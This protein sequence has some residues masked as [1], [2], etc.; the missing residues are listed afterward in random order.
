MKKPIDINTWERKDLFLFFKQFEEPF[1]GVCVEVDVTAAYEQSK[2]QGVS[3]FLY[4]LHK[5]LAA[6]N[7][8]EAFRYR[9]DGE[10]VFLYDVVHASP[11][12]N[13]ANGTF[14]FAYMDY[15]PD[16]NDFVKAAQVEIERIQQTTGL[17]PANSS[18]N[19]IHF[20][21]LPWLRFTGLSHARSFSFNDSIPKIS[22]G[23]ASREGDRLMMPVSIHAHHGL[24]DGYHVGL[25]VER[26][27]ELLATE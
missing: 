22:F 11:T 16:F 1:F 18:E 14:G 7:A 24:V 3:F 9:I 17:Q 23:K 6:A 10:Q 25:F 5:A 13:R 8:V 2:A 27:Q 21:S 19:V 4:Y 26:F 20:S 12:I 15:L